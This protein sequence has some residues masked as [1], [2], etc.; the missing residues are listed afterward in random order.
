[1]SSGRTSRTCGFGSGGRGFFAITP[2]RRGGNSSRRRVRRARARGPR[3]QYRKSWKRWTS[4][5]L[6]ALRDVA[7]RLR[8]SDRRVHRLGRFQ[9]RDR[10][11]DLRPGVDRA[12]RLCV[13]VAGERLCARDARRQRAP[14]IAR[15]KP[16]RKPVFAAFDQ[17]QIPEIAV[18]NQATTPLGLDL[19]R[20]VA[21]LQKFVT[22][23]VAPVWGTPARL[24]RASGFRKGAWAFVSST[25][26]IRRM[27]SP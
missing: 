26:P 9:R 22:G 23:Y 2:P 20:L 4:K 3:F 27:R 18:F 5:S 25:P 8:Y 17:G 7:D 21:A 1:M 19:D 16:V 24:A 12:R 14:P 15:G 10:T 11:A 13:L 6:N